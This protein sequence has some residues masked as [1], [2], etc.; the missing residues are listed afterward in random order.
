MRNNLQLFTLLIVTAMFLSLCVLAGTMNA[1][2][3][4]KE[5]SDEKNSSVKPWEFDPSL[6]TNNPK[7][8][9]RTWEY[10]KPKNAYRDPNSWFDSPHMAYP[11]DG[12]FTIQPYDVFPYPYYPGPDAEHPSYSPNPYWMEAQEE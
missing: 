9:D 2:Q 8:G 3:P 4:A 12:T 6:Y 1:E 10:K 11:F 7:T 5:K